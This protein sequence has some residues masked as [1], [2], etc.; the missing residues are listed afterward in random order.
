M[1]V[2]NHR[3]S[4][5]GPRCDVSNTWR[6]IRD[7]EADKHVNSFGPH[8]AAHMKS[9]NESEG[10]MV[11]NTAQMTDDDFPI[12]RSARW[13]SMCGG[14]GTAKGQFEVTLPGPVLPSRDLGQGW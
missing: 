6:Q 7:D 13:L 11:W 10:W 12:R 2:E 4:G 8:R 14:P 9:L 5:D 3:C 1:L